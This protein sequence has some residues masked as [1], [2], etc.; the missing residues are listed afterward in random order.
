LTL[1]VD[2][3]PTQERDSLGTNQGRD[4]SRNRDTLGHRVETTQGLGMTNVREVDMTQGR[5]TTKGN[6][7]ETSQGQSLERPQVTERDSSLHTGPSLHLHTDQNRLII[8]RRTD[9]AGHP[10]AQMTMT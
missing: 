6:K 3:D 8:L 1:P 4:C 10:I 2:I 5:G 7:V 9:K